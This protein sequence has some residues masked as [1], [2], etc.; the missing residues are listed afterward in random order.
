MPKEIGRD[1][2]QGSVPAELIWFS[3]PFM[4]SNALQIMYGMVEML[5]VGNFVGEAG[6]VA[7][8]NVSMLNLLLMTLGMGYMGQPFGL[9]L[10]Y[11]LATYFTAV[12][13][14]IYFFSQRW[15]KRALLV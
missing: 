5:I 1:L 4:I 2:T 7:V 13:A 11:S 14:T 15:R 12:P 8:N 9:F 6:L 10:E 3:F